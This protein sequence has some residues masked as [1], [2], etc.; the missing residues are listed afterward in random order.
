MHLECMHSCTLGNWGVGRGEGGGGMFTFVN[1]CIYALLV[2]G[3]GG[4]VEGWGG[5][6][7]GGGGGCMFKCAHHKN[8]CI[9]NTVYM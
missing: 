7:G 2:L 6:R 4:G 3:V 1:T 8:V 5:G 9:L